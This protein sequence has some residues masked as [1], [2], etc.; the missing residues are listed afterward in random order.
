MPLDTGAVTHNLLASAGVDMS[1]AGDVHDGAIEG[2]LDIG[3]ALRSTRQ[4]LGLSLQDVADATR[5]KRAYLSAL[6]EMRLE[7]LPSR[8]F[9][10]GYVRAYARMLGLDGEAAVERFK[11][12]SPGAIEPLRPPVG[13][14][15]HKDARVP[16]LAC[17]GAAVI[18]AVILWNVAQHAMADDSPPPPLLPESAA[19]AAPAAATTAP[20][21]LSVS[22][23]QPAPQDSDLPQTY[24]TPGMQTAGD[25]ADPAVAGTAE[26]SASSGPAALASAETAA[27]RSFTPHGA[28][29]GAAAQ[30]S[31]VILQARKS[32]SLV[33]R[34]ADGSVYFAQQLKAGEAYRAPMARNLTVDVSDTL[35]FDVYVN[36]QLHASLPSTVTP[37]G[38]LMAAA[39]APADPGA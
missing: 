21:S 8:P 12:D 39:A 9:T 29:Y 24:K 7:D 2:A 16:L 11:V 10:V 38:Q 33:I 17:G 6:E 22:A 34:G 13:V 32:A 31:A 23:A 4:R 18:S 26:A 14:R 25:P 36:G 35:A 27:P 15:K 5:I 20:P 28:V 3:G 37:L 30:G 19:P 1:D